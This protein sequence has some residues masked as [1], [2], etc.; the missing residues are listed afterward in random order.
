MCWFISSPFAGKTFR[1]IPDYQNRF[2]FYKWGE[3]TAFL[4]AILGQLRECPSLKCNQNYVG[5][6][7][8]AF[9]WTEEANMADPQG[10]F[11]FE[12]QLS[13]LTGLSGFPLISK[14]NEWVDT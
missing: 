7:G 4:R 9:I 11:K 12:Q 13:P 6:Q 2:T 5:S 8:V 3:Q 1:H 10:K 14:P